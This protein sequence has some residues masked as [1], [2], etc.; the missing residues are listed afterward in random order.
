[1]PITSTSAKA[2]LATQATTLA[3]EATSAGLTSLASSLTS[4]ASEISGATVTEDEFFGGGASTAVKGG[5]ANVWSGILNSSAGIIS[6]HNLNAIRDNFVPTDSG[7]FWE[8]FS[9]MVGDIGVITGR[10]TVIAANQTIIADKQTIIADKQTVISDK[11]TAME[12][13]QKKLK[14]LAEDKGV[15]IISPYEYLTLIQQY[16]SLV[17]EGN[18]L[19]APTIQKSATKEARAKINDY[20]E[21]IKDLP[22]IKD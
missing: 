11:T 3:A 13:Y 12:T 4:L 15:R 2:L 7:K 14:E 17:E 19:K 5:A 1:M 20:I 16:K 18:V 8:L 10:Q 6:S 22:T 21:S 9:G